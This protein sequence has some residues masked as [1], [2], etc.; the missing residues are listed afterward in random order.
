MYEKY[1]TVIGIT[2]GASSKG[3]FVELIGGKNGWIS[4]VYLPRGVSVLCTVYEVK[5][6]GFPILNL[7][8]VRYKEAA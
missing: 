6:D 3:T 7:D 4:R 8:S 2:A 1:D 5:E